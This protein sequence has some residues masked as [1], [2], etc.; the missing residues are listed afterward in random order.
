V[1]STGAHLASSL[2]DAMEISLTVE[3]ESVALDD[4]SLSHQEQMRLQA[5][6]PRSPSMSSIDSRLKCFTSDDTKSDLE[7]VNPKRSEE[8]GGLDLGRDLFAELLSEVYN[9]PLRVETFGC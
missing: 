2:R 9:T 1:S 7:E 6:T 3:T 5:R 8:G 4:S